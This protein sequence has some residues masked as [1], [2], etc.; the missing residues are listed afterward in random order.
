MADDILKLQTWEQRTDKKVVPHHIPAASSP[1]DVMCVPEGQSHDDDEVDHMPEHAL[2]L[3][4]NAEANEGPWSGFPVPLVEDEGASCLRAGWL[5]SK[6][7]ATKPTWKLF[8]N[9]ASSEMH[10][11]PDID[12]STPTNVV[13][14]SQGR[15]RIED[16]SSDLVVCICAQDLS[17]LLATATDDRFGVQDS[18][19]QGGDIQES[20]DT[21]DQCCQVRHRDL[22]QSE[23]LLHGCHVLEDGCSES[24]AKGLAVAHATNELAA[25]QSKVDAPKIYIKLPSDDAASYDPGKT[26]AANQIG[27]RR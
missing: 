14:P 20:N 23:Q 19:D 27:D 11:L 17:E 2:C 16:E 24:K 1:D 22:S 13:S 8:N 6:S 25:S 5:K 10:A 3:V 7:I 21:F 26:R 4:G 15:D 9:G 12:D 18:Q